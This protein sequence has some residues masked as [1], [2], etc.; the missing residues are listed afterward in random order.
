MRVFKII[1][2]VVASGLI[3]YAG[4]NTEAST[5]RQ[6]TKTKAISVAYR[7]PASVYKYAHKACQKH[8][9]KDIA[10]ITSLRPSLSVEIVI[11]NTSPRTVSALCVSKKY[12]NDD[13]TKV[14]KR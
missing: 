13:V 9:Q 6:I 1:T 10:N 8:W 14:A 11:V 12:V 5:T 2:A 7:S 4:A 3:F